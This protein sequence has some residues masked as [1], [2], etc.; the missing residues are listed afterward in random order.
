MIQGELLNTANFC[1]WTVCNFDGAVECYVG[2]GL[3][4]AS[5]RSQMPLKC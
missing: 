2:T 4:I 1:Q 5:I 3:D